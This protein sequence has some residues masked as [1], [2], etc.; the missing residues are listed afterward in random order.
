MLTYCT[1]KTTWSTR[2]NTIAMETSDSC[3]LEKFVKCHN[4]N[5]LSNFLYDHSCAGEN[6]PVLK[7]APQLPP[8]QQQNNSNKELRSDSRDQYEY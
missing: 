2:S 1:I 5:L 8:P 3:I 7:C 6:E 4:N